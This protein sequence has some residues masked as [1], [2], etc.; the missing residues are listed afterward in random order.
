[1]AEPHQRSSLR[2]ILD[3]LLGFRPLT[4]RWNEA[5]TVIEGQYL[6]SASSYCECRISETGVNGLLGSTS[7]LTGSRSKIDSGSF[8]Q[9]QS[10]PLPRRSPRCFDI[11]WLVMKL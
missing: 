5:T 8:A 9:Q 2:V 1:M 4:A 10:F 6:G 3:S 7:G 11:L